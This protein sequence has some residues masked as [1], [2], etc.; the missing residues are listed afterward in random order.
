MHDYSNII[1]KRQQ[2]ELQS[3][4]V[5][6]PSSC[7]GVCVVIMCFVTLLFEFFPHFEHVSHFNHFIRNSRK[8][9]GEMVV[10]SSLNLLDE[11]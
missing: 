9:E 10:L 8:N 7:P 6:S 11:G 1:A 2:Y 3:L 4:P 5:C